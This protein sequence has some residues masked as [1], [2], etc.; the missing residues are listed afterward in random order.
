[1]S[2]DWTA[3]AEAFAD[4]VLFPS[5]DAV[6]RMDVVPR[7]RL[8]LVAEGGWY[9]L[10]SPSS[11]I[12][13]GGGRPILEAFAGGCLTTTLVW[14]QHLGQPPACAFGAE[15]L[16]VW[17]EPL[18][19]GEIRSTVAYAGL[20]PDAPLRACQDGDDWVLDGVAPWVS[21]WGLTTMIH[22]A[23]RAE[24]DDVVW[25]L[26][27][28]PLPGMR[29]EPH[30]LLALD[31]SATV[32][33]HFDGVRVG[34]D[35]LTSR[36]PWADWP[37]RDAMGL[38]TNGSLALGLTARCLRLLGPSA[39]DD[40]LVRVRADLDAG[41]ATT[42]PA[43]RAAACELAVRAASALLV[44]EGSGAVERGRTAERLYREAALLLVFGSR[45][46]IRSSLL[47]AFGAG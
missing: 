43:R 3:R 8:D 25:L 15:H 31:A 11:G 1:V 6:D 37:A 22:V 17:L 47:A 24:D 38:R 13:M 33:L 16:R 14:M 12:D 19:S 23:A 29:A 40:E 27:D 32:T 18:A 30:R 7:E 10:S 35:R 45:P 26:A 2:I 4:E 34:G 39:L 5:A 20:R 21:G 28:A 46:A 36:F 44:A 9:G 41:D 42:Y